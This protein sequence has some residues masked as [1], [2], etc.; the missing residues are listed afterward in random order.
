MYRGL[1]HYIRGIIHICISILLLTAFWD[2]FF[3]EKPSN[4]LELM[5]YFFLIIIVLLFFGGV[6]E[7]LRK[8]P[9]G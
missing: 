8:N 5:K 3:K 6:A 1:N 7:I 2:D 9:K 4:A